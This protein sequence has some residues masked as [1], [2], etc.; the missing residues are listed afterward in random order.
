MYKCKNCGHVDDFILMIRKDYTVSSSYT[1]KVSENGDFTI[2]V[3]DYEFSPSLDF[4]NKHAVCAF[5]S[6][7]NCWISS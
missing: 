1:K 7:I 3:G 4:M 6:S 5:C 2:V